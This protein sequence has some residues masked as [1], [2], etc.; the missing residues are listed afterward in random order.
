MRL[1]P[2]LA[3]AGCFSHS[4]PDRSLRC[5]T[6]PAR[7]CPDGFE[8]AADDFCYRKNNVP[9]LAAPP[10]KGP[11][12]D[13]FFV[14]EPPPN[15]CLLDGGAFA[16]PDGMIT[17]TQCPDDKNRQGCLCTAGGETAPCWPG[18]RENRGL[19]MCIDGVT[20]CGDDGT[21][22]PCVGYVLPDPTATSGAAACS[23]F[24]HGQ[25]SLTQ[26]EPCLV[27]GSGGSV[28]AISTVTGGDGKPTCPLDLRSAPAQPW[29]DDTVRVDC[30]GRWHLCY[31]LKAGDADQPQAS[32]CTLAST[33]ID[34]DYL[35]AGATQSLPPLPGWLGGATS[36]AQQFAQSGGYGEMSVN[37][38]ALDC[39]S[40]T[41]VF[42]RVK[43]C[44]ASCTTC[45]DCL[46]GSDGTF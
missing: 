16:A 39:E 26:L 42:N 2:L 19:G 36:C 5:S 30:V 3:L 9:D 46:R 27:T 34:V 13:G 44:P 24:S 6:D 8:C 25:W 38:V 33:C 4:P 17:S 11:D 28:T 41:R 14:A 10:E 43:Y 31:T 29:T 22:G 40:V 21:W 15:Y 35:T 37:G 23:C 32:D 18:R 7:P 45:T 12:N 1:L 20:T